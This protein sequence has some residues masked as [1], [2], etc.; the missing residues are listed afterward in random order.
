M[1]PLVGVRETV[2]HLSAD[3]EEDRAAGVLTGGITP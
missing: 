3:G 1:K 2:A